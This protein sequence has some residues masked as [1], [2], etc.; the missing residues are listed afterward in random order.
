MSDTGSPGGQEQPEKTI[1]SWDSRGGIQ[2][3]WLDSPFLP[4]RSANA[5]LLQL[6][7]VAASPLRSFPTCPF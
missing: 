2:G 6:A 3:R 7:R 1:A 4:L 5:W